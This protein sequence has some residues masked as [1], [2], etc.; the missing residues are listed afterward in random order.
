MHYLLLLSVR[1][2]VGGITA[3][4]IPH[5]GVETRMVTTGVC[6]REERQGPLVD[7]QLELNPL[8]RENMDVVVKAS[9]RPLQITYDEVREVVALL[10][11]VTALL[12][13]H[14]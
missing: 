14:H 5:N 10:L 8:E 2:G 12:T 6:G 11:C 1:A 4:G 13:G 9:V 7:F 3:T